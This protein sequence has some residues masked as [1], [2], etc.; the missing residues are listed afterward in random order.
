MLKTSHIEKAQKLTEERVERERD[1]LRKEEADIR[2][3]M[4]NPVAERTRAA[5]G[6]GSQA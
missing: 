2:R 6:R 4:L 5:A 3:Q 1:L